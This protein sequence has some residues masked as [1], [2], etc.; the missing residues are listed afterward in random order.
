MDPKQEVNS[1]EARRTN[2]KTLLCAKRGEKLRFYYARSAEKNL[3]KKNGGSRASPARIILRVGR[4]RRGGARQS[5]FLMGSRVE[6]TMLENNYF[7]GGSRG[8]GGDLGIIF[9]GC[10]RVEGKSP[11]NSIR[12]FDLI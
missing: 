3:R 1:R 5:Y 8:R 12:T 2:I 11:K 7:L 9:G 10:S 6:G 4:V